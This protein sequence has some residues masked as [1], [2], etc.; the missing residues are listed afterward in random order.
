MLILTRK[1]DEG[2]VFGDNIK[3]YVL[4][5]ED[6]KVKIGIDAPK[7]VVILRSEVYERV[8]TSNKEA[9]ISQTSLGALKRELDKI[10]RDQE[11]N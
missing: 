8:G 1:K 2:I 3:V 9:L 5:I 11:K 7:N 4:G 6:N 10:G